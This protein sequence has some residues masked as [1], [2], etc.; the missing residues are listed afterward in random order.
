MKKI[1]LLLIGLFAVTSVVSAAVPQKRGRGRKTTNVAQNKKPAQQVQAISLDFR[2]VLAQNV[3]KQYNT[4]LMRNLMN[5][6]EFVERCK[7]EAFKPVVEKLSGDVS[8]HQL[9][10]REVLMLRFASMAEPGNEQIVFWDETND[11]F[12]KTTLLNSEQWG[13]FVSEKEGTDINQEEANKMY[14][15]TFE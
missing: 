13:E 7:L 14:W 3:G 11:N 5:S 10:G 8:S 6:P 15:A 12:V 9:N 1:I 2:S 4:Q